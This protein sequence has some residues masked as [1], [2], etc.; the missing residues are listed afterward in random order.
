MYYLLKPKAL[1]RSQGLFKVGY[2]WAGIQVQDPTLPRYLISHVFIRF[3][4]AAK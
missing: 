3:I 2:G 4:V 1:N